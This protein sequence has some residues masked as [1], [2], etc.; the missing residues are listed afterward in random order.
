MTQRTV[1][2]DDLKQ[3]T[4]EDVLR[5]VADQQ[6]ELTVQLPDGDDIQIRPAP[7][8]KPLPVLKGYVPEGWKDAINGPGE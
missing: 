8:L 4:I 3:R 5:E 6:E 7:R 2:L 1:A